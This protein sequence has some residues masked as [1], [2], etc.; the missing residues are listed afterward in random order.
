M[1]LE[2]E[3]ELPLLEREEWL[4]RK[5]DYEEEIAPWIEEN[6]A[7]RGRA[8][9][10]PVYDFLFD[11]Y[12]FRPSH[13]LQWS[14]GVGVRL[15]GVRENE[16]KPKARRAADGS[17][18]ICHRSIPQKRWRYIHWAHDFLRKTSSRPPRFNCYGLHEWAMV[19]R[20]DDIRH[21]VPLRLPPHVIDNFVSNQPIYCSHYDAFRFFTEEARPLNRIQPTREEQPLLDQP[22]CIHVTM[23]LYRLAYKLYPWCSSELILESLKLARIARAI[24]MRASPY[25]LV[26]YGLSPIKIEEEEGRREYAELQESLYKKGHPT[27][28]K[29]LRLY[30]L[31]GD[32]LQ[33]DQC[34]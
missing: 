2:T 31:L 12:S 4:Q 33:R 3:Q 27:R 24:D 19:Y 23:D 14:P 5:T 20:T 21:S 11:Y 18:Y 6:L 28:L 10:H 16:I 25:D 29:L 15:T 34:E 26:D 13:L 22:G 30:E 9:K 7:R 32:Q 17:L 8:Q 1:E